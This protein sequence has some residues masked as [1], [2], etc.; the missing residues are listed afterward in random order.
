MKKTLSP[1]A[2]AQRRPRMSNYT[3]AVPSNAM[4]G[5]NQP[6]MPKSRP[7]AG[8]STAVSPPAELRVE[9]R[10][11]RDAERGTWS[12]HTRYI[13]DVRHG[14]RT[15]SNPKKIHANLLSSMSRC[16]S[17]T[18]ARGSMLR[19]FLPKTFFRDT[20]AAFQKKRSDQLNAYLA[21][22]SKWPRVWKSRQ[23]KKFFCPSVKS[24][25]RVSGIEM[26]VVGLDRESRAER[27]RD[28]E[29]S[30]KLK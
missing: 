26:V 15:L 13:L 6:R 17:R 1:H 21:T 30:L 7:R 14:T 12:A 4:N 22:I 9:I 28:R 16:V 3:L 10:G 29:K 8:K 24:R 23:V 20:S 18:A 11:T 2:W 19:V 5:S 27:D 25:S